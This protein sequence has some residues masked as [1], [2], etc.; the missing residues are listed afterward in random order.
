M[1]AS[2]LRS[3]RG[4]GAHPL[5]VLCASWPAL[6]LAGLVFV[7]FFPVLNNTFNYDDEINLVQNRH[8]RGLGWAQLHWMFTTFHM[9]HYQ[10]LSWVTLGLDYVLWG[11]KP[12]GY[13]LTNLLLH[14]GNTILVYLLAQAC[15]RRRAPVLDPTGPRGSPAVRFGA[16]FAA[17]LFALH[18]LRVESVAWVTERRDVLSSF[19]LLG[20]VLAY[21]RAHRSGKGPRS[22]RWLLVALFGFALSLLSRAMGVTLPAILL[23]L[24][25]YPLRRLGGGTGRWWGSAVRTVW[26][27][28][29]PFALLAVGAA[30]VAPLAQREIGAAVPLSAHGVEARLAQSCY[31]L[32][33]YL[34]K[35]VAPW[36]LV[37]MVELQPSMR[38]LHG[39]YLISALIVVAA[40][41][42]LLRF[43]GRR[44]AWVSVT[45]CHTVLLLPV[46]GFFQSGDQE[47]ADRYSYLPSIGWAILVGAGLARLWGSMTLPRWVAPGASVAGLAAL[48]VLSVLTSRQCRIWRTDETLWT[49]AIGQKVPSAT[50]Q[51][52]LGRALAKQGRYD[53]AAAHFRQ[54][55]EIKP[56]YYPGEVDL[57]LLL[58]ATQRPGEAIAAFNRAL[59]LKPDLAIVHH[60]LGVLL[61]GQGATEPAETHLREAVRLEPENAA[62]H[63]DLA[64][65]W[66]RQEKPDEAMSELRTAI[67]L[68][69]GF[70]R[71]HG[72]LG[73]LLATQGK[74]EEAIQAYRD[75]LRADPNYVFAH[76]NLGLALEAQDRLDEAIA[77]Y[78]EVLRIDPDSAAAQQALAAAQAHRGGKP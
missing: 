47:V 52:N 24:D 2:P 45:L 25:Y 37:P 63:Y 20:A 74:T 70:V 39:R 53:E 56:T 13:H 40:V 19:F 18:P 69:F 60:H 64:N 5:C 14:M 3:G 30:V 41:A 65:L 1:D 33:F 67:R 58:E 73:A 78:R 55:L 35:T 57:G 66:I 8:Y 15:L 38:L 21:F 61:V 72:N 71:A 75:A 17:L 32:V 76:Y 49:H 48:G 16:V 31:G 34:W 11:M 22:Q 23:V 26:L 36:G 6:V 50:A 12:R 9:G 29:L 10:P 77:Q 42:V 62:S 7:V 68:D 59:R 27:E 46:L 44:P 51:H 54:A 43:G 4:A 28:K